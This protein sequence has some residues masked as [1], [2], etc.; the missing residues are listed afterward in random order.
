MLLDMI[1]TQVQSKEIER[2]KLYEWHAA[3]GVPDR[4]NKSHH[5]HTTLASVNKW[6]LELLIIC[7]YEL[8]NLP[9]TM[10]FRLNRH[11]VRFVSIH[12]NTEKTKLGTEK[13]QYNCAFLL[14]RVVGG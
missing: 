6:K 10:P 7:K 12:P 13:S 9:L 3:T 5:T 2:C 11:Q 14:I 4:A 8:T 1:Q